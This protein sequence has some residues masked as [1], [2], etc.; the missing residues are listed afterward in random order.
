MSEEDEDGE[1]REL[2]EERGPEINKSKAEQL[3]EQI[4]ERKTMETLETANGGG[5]R[6]EHRHNGGFLTAASNRKD[7]ETQEIV[8]RTG[9]RY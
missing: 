9:L 7:E 8:W 1:G 2:E 6:G 5:N 3:P 4:K